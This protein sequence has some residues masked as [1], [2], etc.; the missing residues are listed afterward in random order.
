MTVKQRAQ[1]VGEVADRIDVAHLAVRDQAC[2][3]CPVL[4]T[5]L[6]PG[7][8]GVF[9]GQSQFPFI[10]PMSGRFIVSIIDGMPILA[11]M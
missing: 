5:D 2:E 9:P 11:L 1:R 8:E 10:L 7:E 4:C 6:V 3:Q